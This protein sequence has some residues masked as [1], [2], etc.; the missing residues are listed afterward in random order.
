MKKLAFLL[1]ST[2]VIVGGVVGAG[3]I[4]GREIASFFCRD[5]SFSGIYVA[6]IFFIGCIFVIM[7]Y[8]GDGK[9]Y[10]VV[11]NAVA[12]SSVI[13]T[14]CMIGAVKNMYGKL[15][16]DTEKVKILMIITMVFA[17]FICSVGIG[18]VTIFNL[19]FIPVIMLVLLLFLL[20]HGVSDYVP[21]LSPVSVEGAYMPVLYVGMNT[22]TSFK[23]LSDIGRG[24][25]L[26]SCLAVSV[27]TSIVLIVFIC[28]ISGII[29]AEGLSDEDMPLLAVFSE[30][31]FSLSAMYAICLIGIYTTLLCSMYSSFSLAKGNFIT[32]KRAIITLLCVSLSKFGF[33]QIVNLFYPVFGVLGIVVSSVIFL[34]EF[35][36]K[37]QR[38][39]TLLPPKRIKS[40]CLP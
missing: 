1:S 33:V 38:A 14:A 3:F 8:C 36:P 18:F 5:L 15:L 26:K 12:I 40:R 32:I 23:I 10:L 2:S 11:K 22:F 7:R 4:T 29:N 17:F 25:S 6:F 39:H 24:K 37:G 19:I 28:L 34:R 9:F 13:I 31:K 20:K 16:C 27:L 21:P 35:F 30:G